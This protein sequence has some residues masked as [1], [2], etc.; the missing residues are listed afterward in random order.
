MNTPLFTVHSFCAAILL[1]FAHTQLR[2]QT[3]S[4]PEE[5]GDKARIGI[6]VSVNPLAL[7][8]DDGAIQ[9]AGVTAWYIPVQVGKHVRFETEVSY[10]ISRNQYPQMLGTTPVQQD[11]TESYLRIGQ[12]V[13][14]TSAV[15]ETGFR[16]YTGLRSGVLFGNI[17][18]TTTVQTRPQVDFYDQ[19]K[20]AFWLGASLGAEHYFSRHVCVGA[21]LQI[22]WYDIGTPNSVRSI[23]PPNIGIRYPL[24]TQRSTV[25]TNGL[26]FLRFFF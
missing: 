3:P 16:W 7:V 17:S 23:P 10:T 2:A 11:V 24:D 9:P 4:N 21:E 14:Y 19:T 18:F 5:A 1:L 12:G 26:L 25:V 22:T 15:D 20:A 6:G 13:F 8:R